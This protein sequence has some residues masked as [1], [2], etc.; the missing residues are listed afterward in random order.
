MVAVVSMSLIYNFYGL[1]ITLAFLARLQ[2]S[3]RAQT[4]CTLFYASVDKLVSALV[5]KLCDLD[6]TR[7]RGVDVIP[8]EVPTLSELY[9]RKN[10]VSY[11]C[12]TST[13][14]MSDGSIV[15]WRPAE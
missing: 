4:D 13:Y 15:L 2:Q 6:I 5:I 7:I 3:V 8:I 1:P 14:L 10:G 12:N 11:T 9:D